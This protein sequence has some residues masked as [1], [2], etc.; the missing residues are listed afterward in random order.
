MAQ[1]VNQSAHCI[2]EILHFC[3]SGLNQGITPKP[4]PEPLTETNLSLLVSE[5]KP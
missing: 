4:V 3:I 5:L 2:F 1:Q